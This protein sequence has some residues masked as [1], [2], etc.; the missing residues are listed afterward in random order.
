MSEDKNRSLDSSRGGFF[1]GLSDRIRLIFRLIAD[2]RIN[3]LLKILPI[4]SLVYLV[5]PDIAPGP[6][7]D[8]AIIWLGTYLFVELCPP[9]VVAEHLQ[10]LNPGPAPLTSDP[11]EKPEEIIDAEFWEEK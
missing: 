2:S 7:D 3:P 10:A 1:Q 6:I 5:L 9:D 4:G 8:A 11:L